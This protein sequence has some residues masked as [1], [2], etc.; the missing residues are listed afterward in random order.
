VQPLHSNGNG[1]GVGRA[2]ML[3]A[4]LHC[5]TA[6]SVFSVMVKVAEF[7]VRKSEASSCSTAFGFVW[8]SSG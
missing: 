4:R 6:F 7:M 5:S 2:G 1:P 3:G 8:Q